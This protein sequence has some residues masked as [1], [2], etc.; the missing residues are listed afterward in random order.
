VH[1]DV[2]RRTDRP[3]PWTKEVLQHYVD[4]PGT[5]DTV[6]G[7]ATWRLLEELVRQRVAEVGVALEWLVE[8]GYL[9]KIARTPAAPPLY[10]MKTGKRHEAEQLITRQAPRPARRRRRP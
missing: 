7:I 4:F 8:R 3:P 5:A 10:R 2:P 1:R 9:E 6:E